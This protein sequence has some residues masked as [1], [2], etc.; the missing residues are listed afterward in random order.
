MI[1]SQDFRSAMARLATAVNI[2][3]TRGQAGTHGM[4]VSAVC[5]VTD[6]PPTLL[7]CINRNATA[8]ALFKAN[9]V[10]CVNVL[11]ASQQEISDCFAHAARSAER[12]AT[13]TWTRLSTGSPVLEGALVS[14]DC[15]IAE[16]SEVGTHSVFYCHVLALC[17]PVSGPG[18]VY[19]NRDYHAVC[20][21]PE[22]AI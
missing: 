15:R 18:L 4:T 5:S 19:F 12:F 1:K 16:V 10:L 11:S 21:H 20:S 2:V 3:T 13:G 6:T 14:L 7:V 8:N 22:N 9:G 17:D